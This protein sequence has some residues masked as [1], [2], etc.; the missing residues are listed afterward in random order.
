MISVLS[1][2]HAITKH[3]YL[4]DLKQQ[5][6]IL[7]WFWRLEIWNEDIKRAMLMLMVLGKMLPCFFLTSSG[8]WHFLGL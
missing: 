7:S 5:K 8:C 2:L 1:C 6:I 3:H 4:G